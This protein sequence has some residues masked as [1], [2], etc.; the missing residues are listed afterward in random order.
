MQ[1]NESYNLIAF[2]AQQNDIVN[3]AII[4]AVIYAIHLSERMLF[5]T[6]N[7]SVFCVKK[8]VSLNFLITLYILY[9]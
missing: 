1:A 6:I 5:F 4:A 7:K 2:N 8:F 9:L 3:S